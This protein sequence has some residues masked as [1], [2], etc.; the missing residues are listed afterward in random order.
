MNPALAH[1]RSRNLPRAAA[2]AAVVA[3]ATAVF[4][5]GQVDIPDFRHLV[6]YAV[7]VA[8]VV[9]VAYAVVLG[10]TLHTPMADLEHVSARPVPLYRRLQLVALTLFAT[11]LTALP[12]AFGLPVEVFT[13]SVRNA[14]GYLGLA[15]ISARFFG[16]GLAWLL[17]LATFG[18]TLLLGVGVDNTPEWWAWSIH[19]ATS[20]GALTIAA[21]LWLAAL[22]LPGPPPSADDRAES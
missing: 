18:P 3:L 21:V 20:P 6:D 16:S 7:P 14:A 10:T 5:R 15:V 2:A 9:P 4:T 1:A 8:A 11:A 12:L 22:L 17:P 19:P 13:A